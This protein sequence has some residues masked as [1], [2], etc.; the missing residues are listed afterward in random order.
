MSFLK[1]VKARVMRLE[2]FLVTFWLLLF[3]F[4]GDGDGDGRVDW[5]LLLA[6]LVVVEGLALIWWLPVALVNIWLL[7]FEMPL[8]PFCP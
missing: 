6:L 2:S 1:V 5:L 8:L 4:G 7:S 3:L